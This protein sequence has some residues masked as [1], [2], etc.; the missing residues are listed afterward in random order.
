MTIDEKIRLGLV[1]LSVVS[2]A[3]VAAHF[4]H[5]SVPKLPF[6]EELGGGGSS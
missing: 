2:A 1:A 3:I 6:L 4:G 5:A